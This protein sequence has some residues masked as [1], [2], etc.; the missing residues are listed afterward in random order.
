MWDNDAPHDVLL[1][2]ESHLSELDDTG[3]DS[4][5]QS[6]RWST[7]SDDKNEGRSGLLRAATHAMLRA[8]GRKKHQVVVR[9]Q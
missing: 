8:T 4:I 1:D 7:R 9:W 6:C 3:H 5:P 2:I